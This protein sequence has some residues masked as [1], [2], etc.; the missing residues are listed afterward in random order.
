MSPGRAAGAGSSRRK[1]TVAGA[2]AALY[3][4]WVTFA[5][6]LNFSPLWLNG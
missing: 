6:A 5:A 4:L 3:L 1:H 2:L